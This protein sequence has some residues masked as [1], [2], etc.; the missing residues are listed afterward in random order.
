LI[1]IWHYMLAAGSTPFTRPT[2]SSASTITRNSPLATR[3]STLH[4]RPSN[5]AVL[6]RSSAS[7]S[8]LAAFHEDLEQVGSMVHRVL[9]TPGSTKIFVAMV[10]SRQIGA[11]ARL[12]LVVSL[13]H[14]GDLDDDPDKVVNSEMPDHL[15]NVPCMLV[16]ADMAGKIR[17]PLALSSSLDLIYLD[18]DRWICSS[19]LRLHSHGK[20]Q[21]SSSKADI[22][23]HYFLPSDWVAGNE[24]DICTI[25]H[26]GT[27][28]CP[29]NGIV[30]SVECSELGP[31]R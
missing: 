6:R 25:M 12:Y 3:S 9:S 23:E 13:E 22:T 29:R 18:N 8:E 15:S 31:I 10:H 26:D 1:G 28:L 14:T 30:I 7:T 4:S 21:P 5:T 20:T 2:S 24:S 19:K 16:P 11:I 27:L 17:E